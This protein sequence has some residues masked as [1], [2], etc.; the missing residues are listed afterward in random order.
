MAYWRGVWGV[1][2]VVSVDLDLDLLAYGRLVYGAEAVRASAV[3]L[4][5]RERAFDV[6]VSLETLEHLSDVGSF[7]GGVKRVL[8]GEGWFILS[9]PNK[10]YSSPFLPRPLNPYHMREWYLGPLL[11]LLEGDGFRVLAVYGGKAFTPSVLVRRIFG[12][13]I[14]YLFPKFSRFIDKIYKTIS[15]R[16]RGARALDPSPTAVRHQRIV[17]LSNLAL[18][19]YFVVVMRGRH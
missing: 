12:S 19:E 8:K 4:P 11:R 5:F 6:V 1:K 7:L 9:T 2:Y 16:P 14:K 17:P 18:Y 10:L 13:F 3:L 15:D